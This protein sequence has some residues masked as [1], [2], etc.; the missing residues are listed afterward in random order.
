M[1]YRVYKQFITNNK[2]LLGAVVLDEE[3]TDA[4]LICL[5][6][7]CNF[8]A[9]VQQLYV[10]TIAGRPLPK[11]IVRQL[12]DEG[13]VSIKELKKSRIR[14]AFYEDKNFSWYGCEKAI[15]LLYYFPKHDNKATARA[16]VKAQAIRDKFLSL[17]ENAEL[18]IE[19]I[20]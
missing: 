11:E 7:D 18:A 20:I 5:E 3:E 4:L 10:S 16:I 17:K 1:L 12:S 14:L 8:A 9:R 15:V 13:D 6:Q 19:V 2:V